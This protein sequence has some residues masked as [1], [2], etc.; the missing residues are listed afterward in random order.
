MDKVIVVVFQSEQQ[1]YEGSRA[2]HELHRDGSI[3]LF[4]DAVIAKGDSGAVSVRQKAEAGF[5]GTLY[6]FLTGSI[7]GLLGGPVG[8]ALGAGTGSIVGTALDAAR[9]G[10]GDD[11]LHEVS[12]YLVP[13]TA[14]VVA[15]VDE[16]WEI[17]LD[18]RMEAIGGRVFRRSRIDIEDA[19]YE[20]QMAALRAEIDELE[21]ERKKAS[22]ERKA[23]L[24]AK[25]ESAKRRLRETEQKAE[26]R[27]A[28][29]KRESEAKIE[30]LKKQMETA[31][32]ERKAK[33]E[34]RL[35]E[36]RA[37][38]KE[39]TAK[40]QKAWELTKSALTV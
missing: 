21:A 11:F 23:K 8:L 14:G 1:A 16:E 5:E 30:S 28:S 26:V 22:A 34:R 20:R 2:L 37:D 13:K 39:R 18:S 4:A 25:I 32:Q 19:W 27:I 31:S 38:Y 17:P 12:E 9:A 36:V 10:V 40:L 29:L 33:L 35:A 6:G 7:I 24:D 3:T 15:E